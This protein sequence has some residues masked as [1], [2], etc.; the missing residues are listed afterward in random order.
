LA[1]L[2]AVAGGPVTNACHA[3][4]VA[5]YDD[6]AACYDATRGGEPRGDEYAAELD[7]RLPM[8]AGLVL[9]V[10]VGT[11]VVAFGLRRRGR[12]VIGVD[13]APAML[14]RAKERLGSGLVLGD[15]RRLPLAAGTVAHAVSVWVA[16]AVDPPEAMFAEVARVLQPGGRYLVCPT[17]R[18]GNGEVIG[19]VLSAMFAR[20]ERVH[21]TWRSRDVSAAEILAWGDRAGF[22]GGVESMRPRS[23]TTNAAEQIQSI[24]DRVWPALRGLGEADFEAVTRPA[25]DLLAALGE[26]EIDQHADADVVVL[27]LR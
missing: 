22:A 12:S 13:V 8:G 27:S 4:T 20:A 9:E 24:R 11:G 2:R 14:A 25:I 19:P 21:P 15:A 10:G 5:V 1:H 17:N 3:L 18:P 6:V 26:G 7:R 23:W 16:H